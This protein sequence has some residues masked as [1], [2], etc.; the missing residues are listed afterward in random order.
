[1]DD[2]GRSDEEELRLL[3][4][5]EIRLDVEHANLAEFRRQCSGEQLAELTALMKREARYVSDRAVLE[6]RIV[7]L[8]E[9]K[10]I[11]ATRYVAN[12][13]TPSE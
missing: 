2:G 3:L 7:S 13:T 12:K 11:A 4:A 10:N 9:K 1:M 8:V 5:E 6:A